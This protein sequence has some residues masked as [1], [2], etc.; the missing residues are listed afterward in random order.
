MTKVPGT[1]SELTQPPSV[2]LARENTTPAVMIMRNTW[3]PTAH[4]PSSFWKPLTMVEDVIGCDRMGNP[5]AVD[6]I[7]TCSLR[8]TAGGDHGFTGVNHGHSTG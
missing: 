8:A 1:D 4:Q 2:A 3:A 5:V 7:K 6:K